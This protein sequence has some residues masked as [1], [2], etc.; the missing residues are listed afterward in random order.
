MAS[1]GNESDLTVSISVDSSQVNKGFQEV[2]DKAREFMRDMEKT[3]GGLDFSRVLNMSKGVEKSLDDAVSK[4]VDKVSKKQRELSVRLNFKAPGGSTIGTVIKGGAD[5]DKQVEEFRS[6]VERANLEMEKA[7]RST[8]VSKEQRRAEIQR[9][10]NETIR[11]YISL[12]RQLRQVETQMGIADY[13]AKN[14]ANKKGGAQ[15][16]AMYAAQYSSLAQVR[17]SL[18]GRLSSISSKYGGFRWF[19]SDETKTMADLLDRVS[20]AEADASLE[21]RK[22]ADARREQEEAERRLVKAYAASLYVYRLAI[23]FMRSMFKAV[24]GLVS[25]SDELYQSQFKLAA[26]MKVNSNVTNGQVRGMFQYVRALSEANGLSLEANYNAAQILAS[27]V[28]TEESLKGLLSAY[29]DLVIKMKGYDVNSQ[30]AATIAKQLARALAGDTNAISKYGFVLSEAEKK[31][32][33]GGV[34]SNAEKADIL[35]SAIRRKTGDISKESETWAGYVNRVKVQTSLIRSNLGL[36]VQNA[37]YPMLRVV[38]AVSKAFERVSEGLVELSKFVFGDNIKGA[39]EM[40]GWLSE[41]DDELESIQSRLLSFD[42]FNVLSGDAS[43]YKKDDEDSDDS[44]GDVI[45]MDAKE[46]QKWLELIGNITGASEALKVV[47]V[48]IGVALAGIASMAVVLAAMT[49]VKKIKDMVSALGILNKGLGVTK[50]QLGMLFVGVTL[51]ISGILTL[52]EGISQLQNWDELTGTE[53]AVAIIKVISGSLMTLGGLI[54]IVRVAVEKLGAAMIN[55]A[56]MAAAATAAN[57]G[58]SLSLKSIALAASAIVSLVGGIITFISNIQKMGAMRSIVVGFT[59]A[60]VALTAAVIAWKVAEAGP[61]AIA[62]AAMIAG[63]I[64]LAVGSMLATVGQYERGGIPDR[65]QLFIANESGPELVGNIGGRTSVANN[66]MITQAIEEAAYRGFVRAQSDGG[67]NNVTLTLHGD[68]VRND[69]LVR[70]L[71]PALKTEIRRQG[72]V[73]KAFGG[74]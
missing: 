2:L 55:H 10:H 1:A 49:M 9:Q 59:S 12:L 32:L 21:A 63:G 65:G 58:F 64:A 72:G 61:L 33:K 11:E 15:A 57:H 47:V 37:L 50:A 19:N 69:A 43:P 36:A 60:I 22:L 46:G 24:K 34:L 67:S 71:M 44:S 26:A 7:E 8:S 25:A 53:K 6:K 51:L 35:I 62:Q 31:A 74:D 45:G 14:Y 48:G 18:A 38:L 42:K 17:D 68:G 23:R 41:M 39:E 3:L 73:K 52:S 16:S 56:R 4:A 30:Q 66:A 20:K 13:R 28:D 40:A 5:F 70:A 29:D 54:L 27:Y